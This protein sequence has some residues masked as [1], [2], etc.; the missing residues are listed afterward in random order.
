MIPYFE[1]RTFN[2]LGITFQTWGTLVALG[3]STGI[4]IAWKRAKRKGLDEKAILDLAFWIFVAAFIGARVFHVLFYDPSFYLNH[5]WAAIDPREPGFSTF[6]GFIGAM[7]AFFPYMKKHGLKIL[8]YADVLIWGMPLSYGIGR[9]GCFLLR[10]HPGTETSFFLGAQD[11]NGIV[12]HDLGLYLSIA[13]FITAGL[14]LWLDRKKRA[15]GF[16]LASYMIIQGFVRFSLDFLRVA[17]ATYFG[18]T[19]AQYLSIPLFFGG[20]WLIDRK[21]VV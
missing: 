21:S 6:G 2:V 19:P 5:P 7:I 12:R 15:P 1:L 3:F 17:D 9:I 11:V 10:L 20:L 8:T 16:W 4:F 14:F 13:G 18:L